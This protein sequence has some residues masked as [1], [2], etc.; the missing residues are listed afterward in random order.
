MKHTQSG[1][2]LLGIIIILGLIAFGALYKDKEGKTYVE[3]ILGGMQEKK[4]E[5]ID[6]AEGAKKQLED[7]DKALGNMMKE[8][9]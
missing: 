1:F 3:K 9:E 2:S 5:I 7:H 4:E 6:K 8:L